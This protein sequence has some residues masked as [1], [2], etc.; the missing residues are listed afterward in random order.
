MATF[1]NPAAP[2]STLGLTTT[3]HPAAAVP[4]LGRAELVIG[5]EEYKYLAGAVG[6]LAEGLQE[7]MSSKNVV[8]AEKLK[9]SGNCR[10]R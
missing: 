9:R 6:N 5:K 10:D 7:L 2:A 8:L 1:P 3:T 4:E